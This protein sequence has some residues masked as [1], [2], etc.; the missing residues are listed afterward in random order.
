MGAQRETGRAATIS[1]S[2]VVVKAIF[3][4]WT[5]RLID[6]LSDFNNG[7]RIRLRDAGPP[8]YSATLALLKKLELSLSDWS[9]WRRGSESNRRIKVLQTS[10]L[11]LGYRALSLN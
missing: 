4:R 8:A 9:G 1:S 5:T 6:L 3:D 11:P 2:Q 10:P 7:V